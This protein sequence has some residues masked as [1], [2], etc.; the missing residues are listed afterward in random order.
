MT[1][2]GIADLDRGIDDDRSWDSILIDRGIDDGRLWDAD[3]AITD[4]RAR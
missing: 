3:A 1:G 4:R 2:H